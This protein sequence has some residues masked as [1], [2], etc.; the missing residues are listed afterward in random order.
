MKKRNN[1]KDVYSILNCSPTAFDGGSVEFDL[2]SAV[3]ISD[4]GIANGDTPS[5]DPDDSSVPFFTCAVRMCIEVIISVLAV[6]LFQSK[7]G[8]RFN[9]IY[10][11]CTGTAVIPNSIYINCP[12]Y[13]PSDQAVFLGANCPLSN[14]K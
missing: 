11:V 7:Q 13:R 14:V 4:R 12:L 5:T 6:R 3:S 10:T 1:F 2:N 8:V 9:Q